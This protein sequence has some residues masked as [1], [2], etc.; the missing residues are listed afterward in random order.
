MKTRSFVFNEMTRDDAFSYIGR[1]TRPHTHTHTHTAYMQN[2]VTT[3]HQ[4][5]FQSMR[6]QCR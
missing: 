1:Y 4:A 6:T 2:R 3:R 5:L